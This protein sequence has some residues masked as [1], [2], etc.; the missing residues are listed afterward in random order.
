MT[1]FAP[2]A[3][4]L[5]FL[6]VGTPAFAQETPPEK[7]DC[8]EFS[9]PDEA[10]NCVCDDGYEMH[11]P[12]FTCVL[13]PCPENTARAPGRERD[14]R[15]CLCLP[16]YRWEQPPEDHPEG[17]PFEPT[18]CV[19]K[20][21][22]DED[23][24]VRNGADECVCPENATAEFFTDDDGVVSLV[25]CECDAGYV[26]SEFFYTCR[27][28]EEQCPEHSYF[29]PGMPAEGEG[30]VDL[31]GINGE[32]RCDDGYVWTRGDLACTLVISDCGPHAHPSPRGDACEC[33]DNFFPAPPGQEGCVG[34]EACGRCVAHAHPVEEAAE[35]EG[36]GEALT[37]NSCACECNTGYRGQYEGDK[38]VQ[39]TI[40]VEPCA[41]ALCGRDPQ[42]DGT[43]EEADGGGDGGGDEGGC[44][45]SVAGTGSDGATPGLMFLLLALG[46]ALI[47]RRRF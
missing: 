29:D 7:I 39:C 42:T 20:E 6:A 4:A 14:P 43:G 5:L 34:E 37:N 28:T 1:R 46:L 21:D 16:G 30:E 40:E 36:E 25:S 38:L 15:G 23:G 10:G 26:F 22:C 45:N 11:D 8:P 31:D 2:P 44:F 35:G 32:C 9:S 18:R 41:D 33:D 19:V 47:P 17:E 13:E 12:T 3:I 27:A 24:A